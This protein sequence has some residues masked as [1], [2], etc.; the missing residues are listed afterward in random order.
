MKKIVSRMKN[1]HDNLFTKKDDLVQFIVVPSSS[2]YSI[3]KVVSFPLHH[4]PFSKKKS[5]NV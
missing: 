2:R 5:H 1:E 4:T 3:T